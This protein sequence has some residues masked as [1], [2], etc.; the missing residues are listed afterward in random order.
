MIGRLRHTFECLFQRRRVEDDLDEELQSSFEM[1][2]DRY[3]ASGLSPARAR[4]AARIDFEGVEQVKERVRDG[5]PGSSVHTLSQDVLYAWRGLWR[6]PSFA[7]VALVTLGLGIGVNTAVFSVFYG[8]LLRPLPYSEPSRLALI[9]GRVRAAG[10]A[11]ASV[12]GPMLGEVARRNRSLIGVAGTW[13]T[14]MTFAGDHPEQVRV[15]FVTANFFDVLGVRATRGRTFV[16]EE[17]SGQAAALVLSDSYFRRRFG[18]DTSLIGRDLPTQYGPTP[19][20]GVLPADFQLYFPPEANVPAD[21]QAFIPFPFNIYKQPKRL[22]FIRI[23]G[24]LRPGESMAE[25]QRDLDRVAA[26]MRAAFTEYTQARFGLTLTGMQAD[27]VHDVQ[28]ALAALFAGASFVLLICCVNVSGLLVARAAERRR[29]IALRLTVG[30]S[31]GRIVRQLLVEGALLSLLGGAAGIAVGWA[32]FRGLLAI[33]PERLARA[34]DVGLSWPVLA[35]AASVS[36]ASAML[37]GMAPATECLRLNLIETLRAVGRGWLG[38]LHRRGGRILAIAEI[39]LGFLLVTGAALTARS[40]FSI[41]RI[42]PGFE[43]QQLLTFQLDLGPTTRP[44]VE[45][46]RIH[47]WEEQIAALPG[48]ERAGAAS[49]VPLDDYPNWYG[50]YRPEDL[51]PLEDNRARVADFRAVTPGYLAAMGTRLIEGRFFG[52]QD[53]ADARLVAIVD[54]LLAQSTWPNESAVGKVIVVEHVTPYGFREMP[55]TVVGVVEHVRN[56]SMTHQVRGE[57]YLPY[58]QSP[59]SPLT[60]VVRTQTPPLSLA[61]AIRRLLKDQAPERAMGKVQT[62]TASVAR[63]IAPAGFTAVLA[64]AFGVL[65]L[66]LAATGI[67][68]VLNYQVSRR[69]PEMGIRMAVGARAADVLRLVLGEGLWLAAAGVLLGAGAAVAASR[70]LAAVLYGVSPR[71]PLS[72]GVALI[73]LP[74]AALL[75]CWRPARRAATANPAETVRGE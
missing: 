24:R 38:T 36:I 19:L 67:Y 66:M 25:A 30:A 62:M 22:Y 10:N 40:L 32:A 73:L 42:R 61:P 41:Q 54:E 27:A 35:F 50:P 6:R 12:S 57:I 44:E 21:V 49:H 9:W 8:V 3:V 69:M 20:I 7:V 64:A 31:R 39:A 28:P 47:V 56:H 51:P 60:F 15:A 26:E 53:R 14:T 72:Y 58:E 70:W 52:S 74:A 59:R 65:S 17:D 63:D 5:L 33:R 23:F 1:V 34:D 43:P 13:V 4:R 75:G 11:R 18:G 37:F 55:S 46:G 2:V 48:V 68:G 16:P 45:A 29:E 71:D